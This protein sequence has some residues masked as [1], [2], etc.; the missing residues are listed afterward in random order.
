LVKVLRA[1]ARSGRVRAPSDPGGNAHAAVSALSGGCWLMQAGRVSQHAA[2]LGASK[3][4]CEA[5]RASE[6]EARRREAMAPHVL[7]EQEA[8]YRGRELAA[9]AR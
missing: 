3:E 9:P 1:A 7:D 2:R 5:W 4:S 6:A 8:F